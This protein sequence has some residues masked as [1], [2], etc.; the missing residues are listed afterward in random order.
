[1]DRNNGDHANAGDVERGR[2]RL[3]DLEAELGVH[4]FNRTAAGHKLTPH[5]ERIVAK[6]QRSVRL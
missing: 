1:M 6:V 2:A 3:P 5:G 4:V